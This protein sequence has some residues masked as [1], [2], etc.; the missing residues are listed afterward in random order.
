MKVHSV[1]LSSGNHTSSF[2]EKRC[3]DHVHVDDAALGVR[4]ARLVHLVGVRLHALLVILPA[5][6]G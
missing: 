1:T 5:E 3:A 2:I 4:L 6:I